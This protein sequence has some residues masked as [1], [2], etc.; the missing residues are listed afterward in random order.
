MELRYP[1]GRK[2]GPHPAITFEQW[3]NENK[4]RFSQWDD[5]GNKVD[6]L[7]LGIA[8][9]N[10][11]V[12]EYG[13]DDHIDIIAPEM[14]LEL[15]IYDKLGN[16][17]ATWVG[18]TDAAFEDLS[19]RRKSKRR[20]GFFEHKTA[21]QIRERIR[22]NSEY[23]EQGLG[24]AWAGSQVFRE[25]GIFQKGDSVDHVLFNILRKSLPD[26]RPV[27]DGGYALNKPKKDVLLDYCH[28]KGLMIPPK[29]KVEDL[30]LA[31]DA[32]GYDHRLLGER[33]ERQQASLFYRD[34]LDYGEGEMKQTAWRIAAE[35]WEREEVRAGRLP[36]YKSP[37]DHCDWCQF[38]EACEIHEMGGDWRSILELEFAEWDPYE[39]HEMEYK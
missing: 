9:L 18:R 14:P 2:R 38:Q 7:E 22:V 37:G 16:Y 29:P 8:M 3:Y 5:E 17:L 35:A 25:L 10:G 26:D 11:Y 19:K 33:S 6:A 24:Y 34:T 28:A 32:T 30:V 21:K 23:G 4:H 13:N 12:D 1:P 20:V 27:D 15:K 36:V 31:I 39:G